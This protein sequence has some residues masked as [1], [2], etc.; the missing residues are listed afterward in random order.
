MV[1]GCCLGVL[2]AVGCGDFGCFS[3]ICVHLWVLGW[4]WG[5]GGFCL[6][7]LLELE[8]AADRFV[9]VLGVAFGF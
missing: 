7:V 9:W 4:F 8:C 5:V 2:G 3:C 1:F 6:F